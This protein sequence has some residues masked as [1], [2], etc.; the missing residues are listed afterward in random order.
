[1]FIGSF[2]IQ[3]YLMSPIMVNNFDNIT[4]NFGKL[5]MSAIM[6]LYMLLLS[7]IMND[8]QYNKISVNW[9]LKVVVLLCVM[10]YVY[11]NQVGINDKQYLEGM[12]EHH[13]MAI[14][15]SQEIIKKSEDYNVLK[16]AKTIVQQQEDEISK[17]REMINK[18]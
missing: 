2:I 1:M 17:M 6:A 16:L 11:R 9:Y 7:V 3:Y 15:T 12:I 18:L 14:L 10:I 8:Y 13:S 4:N 5:E